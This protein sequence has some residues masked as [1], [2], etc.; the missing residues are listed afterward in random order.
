MNNKNYLSKTWVL[1]PAFNE[2]SVVPEVINNVL[3]FC[4][5]II[6]IDDGSEDSTS[7]LIRKT[8]VELIRHPV[9]LGQGAA[10]QTGMEIALAKK[11]EYLITFD[12][13]GQHQIED[14][15]KMLEI[16]ITNK[17][18]IVLGNRFMNNMSNI[19]FLKLLLLKMAVLFSNVFYGFKI[20]DIHNGLR[21]F[22]AKTAKKIILTQNRMAHAT[23]ILQIIKLHNLKYAEVPNTILYTE[24]SR[25]KGQKL[26]NSISI[27][28]DLFAD[29]LH[30]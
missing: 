29:W 17:Y 16:L 30:K 3:K 27:L 19:P 9:N 2:A 15:L 25:K 4:K 22:T 26:S 5:N 28:F 24:Y 1:I 6:V 7:E 14:A 8:N 18:D 12:A 10:I 11:A 13:D 21:V 23:E 20:T